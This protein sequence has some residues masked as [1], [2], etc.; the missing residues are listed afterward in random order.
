MAVPPVRTETPVLLP[1][2]AQVTVPATVPANVA[3]SAISDGAPPGAPNPVNALSGPVRRHL[4]SSLR[5]ALR[6]PSVSSVILIGRRDGR[7][8]GGGNFSAG[9]DIREFSPSSSPPDAAP[10]PPPTLRDLCDLVENSHKPIVAALSGTSA[11]SYP[12]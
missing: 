2:S 6:D 12:S 4:L 1:V 11:C 8:G 7:G 9:A 3:V 10:A 5:C